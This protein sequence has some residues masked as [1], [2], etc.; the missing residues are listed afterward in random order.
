MPVTSH[1][2]TISHDDR[3]YRERRIYAFQQSEINVILVGIWKLFLMIVFTLLITVVSFQLPHPTHLTNLPSQNI[4]KKLRKDHLIHFIYRH[5]LHPLGKY[6]IIW[7]NW[8]FI[9]CSSVLTMLAVEQEIRV[10]GHGKNMAVIT[11]ALIFICIN[12]FKES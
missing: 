9:Y 10:W 6:H 2:C 1:F 12:C 8:L 3:E 4:I 7:K 11:L 5:H